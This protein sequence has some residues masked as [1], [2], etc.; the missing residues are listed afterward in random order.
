MKNKKK[1]E[2]KNY[3]E[4]KKLGLLKLSGVVS[5]GKC[6]T[7]WMNWLKRYSRVELMEKVRHQFLIMFFQLSSISLDALSLDLSPLAKQIDLVFSFTP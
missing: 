6:K 5:K 7:L 3:L 2:L 1:K 4:R